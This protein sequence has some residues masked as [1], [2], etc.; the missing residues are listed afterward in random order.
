[1]KQLKENEEPLK[2]KQSV[3]RKVEEDKSMLSDNDKKTKA[4]PK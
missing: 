3:A 2:G 1:V 4:Q